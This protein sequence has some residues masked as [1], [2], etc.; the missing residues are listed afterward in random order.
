[1]PVL[2]K[3]IDI[4]YF[5]LDAN[6]PNPPVSSLRHAG[7]GAGFG[8]ICTL[9]TWLILFRRFEIVLIKLQAIFG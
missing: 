8:P 3:I 5:Q 1:M 9:H 6:P 4:S 7:K 2:N